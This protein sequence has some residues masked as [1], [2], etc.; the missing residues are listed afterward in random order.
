VTSFK[1]IAKSHKLWLE[2]SRDY[3][4]VTMAWVLIVHQSSINNQWSII[5]H[6]SSIIYLSIYLSISSFIS[7]NRS[8]WIISLHLS[9]SFC[10]TLSLPRKVLCS[11]TCA[12]HLFHPLLPLPKEQRTNRLKS[13]VSLSLCQKNE[14][15]TAWILLCL[16]SPLQKIQRTNHLRILLILPFPLSKR[17]QR[18]NRLRYLLFPLYKDSKD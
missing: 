6:L 3:K 5:Y 11:K 9:K 1:E 15:L 14:G 17:F 18:T 10:S 12:I 2:S 13:F 16:S 8:F 4:Y 7:F